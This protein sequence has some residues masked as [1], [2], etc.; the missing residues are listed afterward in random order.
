MDLEITW[1]LEKNTEK[2][3][4]LQGFHAHQ[5]CHLILFYYKLIGCVTMT[6]VQTP[7][8]SK[9]DRLKEVVMNGA[10]CSE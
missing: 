7:S 4:N 6:D 3:G 9:K 8:P 1:H 10:E 2:H 5:T